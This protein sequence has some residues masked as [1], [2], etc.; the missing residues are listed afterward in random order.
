MVLC[1]GLTAVQ[2]L[3]LW[4]YFSVV[5]YSVFDSI[6]LLSPSSWKFSHHVTGTQRFKY[7]HYRWYWYRNTNFYTYES[8]LSGKN[9]VVY[10]KCSHCIPNSSHKAKQIDDYM[11]SR[12][13]CLRMQGGKLSQ[14]CLYAWM[15]GAAYIWLPS[16]DITL[17]Y[18]LFNLMQ[19]LNDLHLL[20]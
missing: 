11:L 2:I 3:S 13:A 1:F 12:F 4:Q 14:T 20:L 9:K 8:L 18:A 6:F 15:S 7:V 5:K 16:Q 10:D 19:I 17:V